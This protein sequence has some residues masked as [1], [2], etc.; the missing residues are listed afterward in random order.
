[1]LGNE[2]DAIEHRSPGV[3]QD[4]VVEGYFLNDSLELVGIVCETGCEPFRANG[5]NPPQAVPMACPR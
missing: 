2:N 3:S 5:D 4:V 1:M